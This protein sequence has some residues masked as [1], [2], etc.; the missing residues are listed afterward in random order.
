MGFA[1]AGASSVAL[2][3]Q[4]DGDGEDNAWLLLTTPDSVAARISCRS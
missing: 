1:I 4:H 3:L 2:F